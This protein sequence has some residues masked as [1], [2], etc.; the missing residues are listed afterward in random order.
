ATSPR[1][2]TRLHL[3]WLPCDVS[4]VPDLYVATR[5]RP[6]EIAVELDAV[7]WVDVDALHLPAKP[8]ALGEARH[9]LQRIAQDHSI[10][11]V[12][13]VLIEVGS[14]GA[15]GDAIEVSE[16]VD[17]GVRLLRLG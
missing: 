15:F 11:P 17:L 13:I 8:F 10:G 5:R 9:H 2:A 1:I 16:Q 14:V 3:L 12:L 4:C 6:L 7:G